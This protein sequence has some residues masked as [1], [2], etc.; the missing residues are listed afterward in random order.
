MAE[1]TFQDL[2]GSK[3]TL[4]FAP[5][6]LRFIFTLNCASSQDGIMFWQAIEQKLLP[7]WSVRIL[8][9]LTVKTIRF[10]FSSVTDK[11]LNTCS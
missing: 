11:G 6:R 8:Q 7:F 3:M 2:K 4:Q 5:C 1:V 10:S 9:G